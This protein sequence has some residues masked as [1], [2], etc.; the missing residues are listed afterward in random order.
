MQHIGEFANEQMQCDGWGSVG[1][2]CVW[3]CGTV[4]VRWVGGSLECVWVTGCNK[5]SK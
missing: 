5:S 4:V 3:R 2:G 1:V